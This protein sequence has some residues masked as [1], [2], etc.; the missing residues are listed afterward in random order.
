MGLNLEKN[1]SEE[2]PRLT[3]HQWGRLLDKVGSRQ[4]WVMFRLMH[5]G[6]RNRTHV[7][8]TATQSTHEGKLRSGASNNPET[9]SKK[10][11]K[12]K[13]KLRTGKKKRWEI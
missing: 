4:V 8:E 1:G 7:T 10:K 6:C 13:K 9:I 12:K 11:K 2:N 3:V 5:L